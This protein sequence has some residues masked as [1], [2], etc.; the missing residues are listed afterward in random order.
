MD[1][2]RMKTD[3]SL[4][5][6]HFWLKFAFVHGQLLKLHEYHVVHTTPKPGTRR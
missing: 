2:A 5:K 4:D 6:R 3:D 1:I